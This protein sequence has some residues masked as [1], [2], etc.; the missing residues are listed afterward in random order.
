MR[1]NL[2][3]EPLPSLTVQLVDP[4]GNPLTHVM[5]FG[6]FTQHNHGDPNLYDRSQAEVYGLDPAKPRTVLFR[7]RERKLGAVLVIKPA[8]AA[9]GAGQR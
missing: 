7:H 1:R 3:V 6:R 2:A 9:K 4:E 8:S 5:A